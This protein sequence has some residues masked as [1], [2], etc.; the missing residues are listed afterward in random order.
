MSRGVSREGERARADGGWGHARDPDPAEGGP[1][2]AFFFDDGDGG[3]RRGAPGGEG[4]A[5]PAGFTYPPRRR[6]ESAPPSPGMG[7]TRGVEF[8]FDDG[9]GERWT[10][11]DARRFRRGVRSAQG[12]RESYRRGGAGGEYYY[13]GSRGGTYSRRYRDEMYA[14]NRELRGAFSHF[15]GRAPAAEEREP[16]ERLEAAVDYLSTLTAALHFCAAAVAFLVLVLAVGANAR[17]SEA[18]GA[19]LDRVDAAW[20]AGGIPDRGAAGGAGF[21]SR[22]A[23]AAGAAGAAFATSSG[24]FEGAAFRLP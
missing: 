19:R 12:A 5:D 21:E 3:F 11:G 13:G 1:G 14:A 15:L 24:G 18:L 20:R 23:G 8:G 6:F 4:F 7:A 17:Q 16:E 2:S 22:A 10:P 9:G